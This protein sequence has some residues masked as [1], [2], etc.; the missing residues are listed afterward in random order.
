MNGGMAFGFGQASTNW[1]FVAWPREID[2]KWFLPVHMLYRRLHRM[3]L[4]H[5][6]YVSVV[7]PRSKL[8]SAHSRKCPWWSVAIKQMTKLHNSLTSM[9]R[10][11]IVSMEYNRSGFFILSPEIRFRVT[12]ISLC[13][14]QGE[15]KT[16]HQL[17]DTPYGENKTAK[18]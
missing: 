17:N 10:M 2:I 13:V 8:H 12:R 16:T 1:C 9:I 11:K 4:D 14:W 7:D 3:L 18:R 15:K 6:I 5:S